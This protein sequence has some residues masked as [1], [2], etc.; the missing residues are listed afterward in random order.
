MSRKTLLLDLPQTV[1]NVSLWYENRRKNICK[2]WDNEAPVS[3]VSSSKKR[4]DGFLQDIVE[5]R[6]KND[7]ASQHRAQCEL[8][9]R[10]M[11]V[12]MR[13]R[14]EAQR[15]WL[16][17]LEKNGIP[18]GRVVHFKSM[19]REQLYRLKQRTWLN[20][21]IVDQ[22]AIHAASSH[23]LFARVIHLGALPPKQMS[24]LISNMLN[25]HQVMECTAS[26][27]AYENSPCF[28][29]RAIQPWLMQV[30]LGA[31]SGKTGKR[32]RSSMTLLQYLCAL[33]TGLEPVCHLTGRRV[34][35][36][37]LDKPLGWAHKN[38]SYPPNNLERVCI[39]PFHWKQCGSITK[40]VRSEKDGTLSTVDAMN[41][42]SPQKLLDTPGLGVPEAPRILEPL[43]RLMEMPHLS[44]SKQVVCVK[45]I[46]QQHQPQK[47]DAHMVALDE[48]LVQTAYIRMILKNMT[49]IREGGKDGEDLLRRIPARIR[50][51]LLSNMN[52]W[53]VCAENMM[54]SNLYSSMYF[55]NQQE[56][57]PQ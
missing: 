39:N 34:R 52:D 32:T 12:M 3:V 49:I 38:C 4:L 57:E 7:S 18:T 21:D 20:F 55:N 14:P 26:E 5:A 41:F 10:L 28:V 33:H 44:E 40:S 9:I 25:F 48:M 19:I 56:Q 24:A 16:L 50:A 29:Y 23:W 1:C 17:F 13:T 37:H 43:R 51:R 42:R 53:M 2:F 11:E 36:S 31:I 30:R 35:Y 6:D 54:Q 22:T 27:A 8:T 15:V 47:H 46:A 45:I